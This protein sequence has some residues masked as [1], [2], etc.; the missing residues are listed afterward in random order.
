MNDKIN[1]INDIQSW[2]DIEKCIKHFYRNPQ[3]EFIILQK[4][5]DK[6]ILMSDKDIE[7][8]KNKSCKCYLLPYYCLN[9]INYHT[10]SNAFNGFNVHPRYE[11][12]RD[13]YHYRDDENI[14]KLLWFTSAIYHMIQNRCYDWFEECKNYDEKFIKDTLKHLLKIC[15]K[16][17]E[18][19]LDILD[20]Q[21]IFGAARRNFL[22]IEQLYIDYKYIN[23]DLDIS[24]IN[25]IID[26]IALVI[27]EIKSRYRF[28]VIY[29]DRNIDTGI[30]NILNN[31]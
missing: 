22:P 3:N 27:Q 18:T 24:S 8:M 26:Y 25:T 4:V 28:I 14:Y 23:K 31:M 21:Y 10:S 19:K 29:S 20:Y 7:V 2:E 16:T 13:L 6:Y 11:I 1:S 15:G 9:D 17:I 12:I 5:N 30:A